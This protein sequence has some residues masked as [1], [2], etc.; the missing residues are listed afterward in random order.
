MGKDHAM[1]QST[2]RVRLQ[3]PA[4]RGLYKPV[5]SR[6]EC[7]RARGGYRGS[8]AAGRYANRRSAKLTLNEGLWMR[9][10]LLNRWNGSILNIMPEKKIRR[11]EIRDRLY[12]RR[13]LVPN[14]VTLANLFCGF[15]TI[16]YATSGRFE[17]AA[18]AI[19]IAILLDGLDGRVARSLNATSKFGVEFDSFS[20][21]VSFGVA[22]AMLVY[23]WCFQVKA[24]EFGVL[25]CFI[26]ALCAASRLARFNINVQNLEKFEGM[27]TPGAAGFVAAMVNFLPAPEPSLVLAAFGTFV[28][29][30]LAGLMVSQIE[31]LSVKTLKIKRMHLTVT[32]ALG[33]VI[34]LVW[35]NSQFGFLTIASLYVLSGPYLAYQRRRV[36]RSSFESEE[37]LAG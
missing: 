24:D 30:S 9:A 21:L 28:M 25:V 14:A 20:D 12:R 16:I 26:Y 36:A 31:F 37:K 3:Q 8:Q 2:P 29:L 22:P 23:C 10:E 6:C 27:P 18:I 15:L 33:S 32:L 19:A 35:Y 17:K 13:Y 7:G 34:A 1:S 5:D 11:V 4:F